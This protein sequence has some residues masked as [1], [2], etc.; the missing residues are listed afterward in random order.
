[1]KIELNITCCLCPNN[2]SQE[3]TMPNDWSF[4]VEGIDKEDGFCPKHKIIAHWANSQCS[5]CIGGWMDCDLWRS[6]AHSANRNLLDSDFDKIECGIC[7]RRTN[8]T[9]SFERGAVKHIDLSEPATVESGIVFKQAILEY[10]D[11]YPV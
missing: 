3:A 9:F 10:W 6:F 8:G 2:Y 1:M 7:P 5:G 11:R 4:H